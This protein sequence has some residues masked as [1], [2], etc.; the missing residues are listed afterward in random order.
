MTTGT[1]RGDTFRAGR[2]GLLTALFLVPSLLAGCAGQDAGP[3]TGASPSGST[4]SGSPAPGRWT[5][6]K[7]KC[8]VLQ[9]PVA[10]VPAATGEGQPTVTYQ[11]TQLVLGAACTWGPGAGQRPRVDASAI[12]F[13]TPTG[14]K[15]VDQDAVAHIQGV[16]ERARQRADGAGDDATAPE[17]EPGL[18][19]EAF[20]VLEPKSERLSLTVRSAN[21]VV[22]V[23][24]HLKQSTETDPGK[25]ADRLRQQRPTV[26]T[27]ARDVLDDLK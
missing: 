23:V 18:G 2:I 16:E 4:E 12:V 7:A 19:D 11:E 9:T 14:D 17:A 3:A 10:D 8:P 13:K 22:S 26:A 15:T 24:V 6:L 27:L 20:V 5:G 21:A 25:L 1:R